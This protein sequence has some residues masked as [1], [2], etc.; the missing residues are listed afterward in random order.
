MESHKEA[1]IF[2]VLPDSCHFQSVF[3]LKHDVF[4]LEAEHKIS[5]INK[6]LKTNV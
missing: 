2:L 3:V 6:I 4:Q 1:D 5:F